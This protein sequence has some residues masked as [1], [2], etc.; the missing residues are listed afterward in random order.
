MLGSD[1]CSVAHPLVH[2][3]ICK[4]RGWQSSHQNVVGGIRPCACK[5]QRPG[6]HKHVFDTR[7]GCVWWERRPKSE[8][9]A[10]PKEPQM[11]LGGRFLEARIAVCVLDDGGKGPRRCHG[12]SCPISGVRQLTLG[13]YKEAKLPRNGTAEP[14]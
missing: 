6:H 12:N 10:G 9:G 2:F 11:G 1:P 13:H 8:F 14:L 5:L 7:W 4:G 3:S